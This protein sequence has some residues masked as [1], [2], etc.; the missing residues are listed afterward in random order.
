MF[1]INNRNTIGS[2]LIDFITDQIINLNNVDQFS[3]GSMVVNSDTHVNNRNIFY[4]GQCL[5]LS[6]IIQIF[7]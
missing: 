5:L 6:K 3:R 1:M 4:D 2:R 7:Y